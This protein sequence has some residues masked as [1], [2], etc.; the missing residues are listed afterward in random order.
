MEDKVR[1]MFHDESGKRIEG[2][3]DGIPHY[4]SMRLRLIAY[5]PCTIHKHWA[6]RRHLPRYVPLSTQFCGCKPVITGMRDGPTNMFVKQWTQIVMALVYASGQTVRDTS[7][8][9]H[10]VAAGATAS[11]VTILAGTGGT[12]AVDTDYAMEGQSAG[13]SGYEAAA[14]GSYVSGGTLGSF[15]FTAT[16]TNVSVSNIAYSENGVE[17]TIGGNVYLLAHDIYSPALTVSPNG[18]LAV[19]YT[20]EFS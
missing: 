4:G 14:I 20:D 15:S 11:A 10:S 17:I 5:A 9:T 7:N 8:A 1:L 16:I 6:V 19:T 3:S 2:I 13:T 18:T 12:P